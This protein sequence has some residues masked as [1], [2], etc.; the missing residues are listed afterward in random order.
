[1]S[2]YYRFRFLMTLSISLLVA[3]PVSAQTLEVL[4][5]GLL[6]SDAISN[7]VAQ[8]YKVTRNSAVDGYVASHPQTNE[9][10]SIFRTCGNR[11]Y[12]HSTKVAGGS[13][14]FIKRTAQLSK[15]YGQGELKSQ[16]TMLDSGEINTAEVEWRQGRGIVVITFTPAAPGVGETQWVSYSI[17]GA[18]PK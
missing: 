12:S 1:M 7:Q 16:S 2:V 8:G 10:I 18:C 3:L 6:V 11:V 4:E 15:L 14:G 17:T 9:A 5:S 13:I